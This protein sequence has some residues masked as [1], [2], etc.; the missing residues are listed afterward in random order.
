M[1]VIVYITEVTWYCKAL[2]I[3]CLCIRDSE[4]SGRAIAEDLGLKDEESDAN[5]D[6]D[7][8]LEEQL[9]NPKLKERGNWE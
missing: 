9:S 8:G 1:Y 4:E 7:D 6:T 2:G 3:P 5:N